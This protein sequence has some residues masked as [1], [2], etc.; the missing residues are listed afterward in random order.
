M[1]AKPISAPGVR[2]GKNEAEPITNPLRLLVCGLKPLW[3]VPARATRTPR[4][5]PSFL[6]GR[7][8]E[9]SRR[10]AILNGCCRS[11]ADTGPASQTRHSSH[12]PDRP[13]NQTQ[14]HGRRSLLNRHL[15]TLQAVAFVVRLKGP[16]A[17]VKFVQTVLRANPHIARPIEAHGVYTVIA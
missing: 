12:W 11:R 5:N 10:R 8:F 7:G 14:A 13:R 6:V 17:R 16:C 9:R 1:P 4:N 15:C 2:S 3:C